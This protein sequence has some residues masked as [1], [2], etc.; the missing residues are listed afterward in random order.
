MEDILLVD[1]PKGVTSFDVIRLLRKKLNIKK[2][3]HAGT[4]DPAASGLMI[5]GIG[6]GTKKLAEYIKLDKEYMAEILVGTETDSDD[7]D[8]EIIKEIN[9]SSTEAAE[10]FSNEKVSAALTTMTGNLNLPVSAYSAIKKDGVPFYKKAYLA[11]KQGK[12]IDEK[13][14]PIR[15]MKVYKSRLE[16]I[17]YEN[18]D[19][20]VVLTVVFTVGSGTYIRSLAKEL[21]RRLGEYPATIKNLKRTK[22]G[23]FKIAD[24]INL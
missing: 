7:L 1:K 3:G 11:K 4:L 17:K 20:K 12:S 22:I 13:E 5:I 18:K 2:M 6:K 24:A 9:I 16:D 8:G 10:T 14:L 15:E 21:G 19:K 23:E